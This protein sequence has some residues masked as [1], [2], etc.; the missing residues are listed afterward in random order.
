MNRGETHEP[1]RSVSISLAFWIMLIG[2]SGLYCAVTLSPKF[3]TFLKLRNQHFNQQIQLVALEEQVDDLARVESALERDPEF[4]VELARVEFDAGRRGDG[5]IAVQP[6]LWLDD[7]RTPVERHPVAHHL[8]WYT[9]LIEAFA[10]DQKMRRGFLLAA[11]TMILLSF[12]FLQDSQEPQLRRAGA[13]V[14][15]RYRQVIDR[16]RD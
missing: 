1:I 7:R 15:T 6:G 3:L 8:P 11:G 2:A 13:A 10:N 5:R 12:T 14:R 4:A 9:P 16:Y